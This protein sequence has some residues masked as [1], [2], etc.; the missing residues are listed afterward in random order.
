MF[1]RGSES[2]R[3]PHVTVHKAEAEVLHVS[4][5]YRVLLKQAESS[6]VCRN[7]GV[8]PVHLQTRH[9]FS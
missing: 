6:A 9:V 1:K 2:K 8:D 3:A 7:Y 4:M 5:G